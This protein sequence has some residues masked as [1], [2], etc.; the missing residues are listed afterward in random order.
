MLARGEVSEGRGRVLFVITR[1][2]SQMPSLYLLLGLGAAV[3][4]A[5]R[6]AQPPGER[7]LNLLSQVRD[8]TVAH[9]E[10]ADAHESTRAAICEEKNSRLGEAIAADRERYVR[11][12]GRAIGPSAA[13]QQAT[14][15]SRAN[16]TAVIAANAAEHRRRAQDIRILTSQLESVEALRDSIRS[17]FSGDLEAFSTAAVVRQGAH[18]LHTA[19]EA[20]YDSYA[21][22]LET[23]LAL[24]ERHFTA[25]GEEEARVQAAGGEASDAVPE[26]SG[27][28]E[29]E[30]QSEMAQRLFSYVSTLSKGLGENLA[31]ERAIEKEAADVWREAA[32]ERQQLSDEADSFIKDLEDKAD[33]L[34]EAIRSLGGHDIRDR[35]ATEAEAAP[36]DPR[37]LK[38]IRQEIDRKVR[39]L[40]LWEASCKQQAN[41]FTRSQEHRATISA[42]ISKLERWIRKSLGRARSV[43]GSGLAADNEDRA[44]NG[45]E[46]EPAAAISLSQQDLAARA[47]SA[48]KESSQGDL[49][50]LQGEFLRVTPG[51]YFSRSEGD[52]GKEYGFDVETSEG[53]LVRIRL[54]HRLPSENAEVAQAQVLASPTLASDRVPLG[55]NVAGM[56]VAVGDTVEDETGGEENTE[57]GETMGEGS[58]TGVAEDSGMTGGV[59]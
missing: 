20:R 38:E 12:G 16:A 42:R 2:G 13:E 46:D 55:L 32:E 33:K 11:A 49:L 44:R 57:G 43:A 34:R 1:G 50:P 7:I 23:M 17:G 21:R 18:E 40:E 51:S 59:H 58:E 14:A 52:S 26:E 22:T 9:E 3:A 53:E 15:N 25:T 48:L 24:M 10:I 29:R 56:A 5:S 8:N 37:V 45:E 19:H 36:A 27:G 35:N 31:A 6:T 39:E 47:F 30:W 28:A 41:I 54:F 4:S